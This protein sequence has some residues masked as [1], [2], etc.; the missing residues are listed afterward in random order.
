MDVA[1]TSPTHPLPPLPYAQDALEPVI[2]R[3]TV[4]FHYSRHH[5]GY[6][7]TLNKLIA[8]TSLAHASLEEIVLHAT[9]APRQDTL[10]NNAAQAWNHAFYWRSLRPDGGGIPPAALL[11][12]L[13][14]DFGGFDQFKQALAAAAVGRFGSGWAWLVLEGG[15]LKVVQTSNADTPIVHNQ[16][17]L[18]TIDVWEHAY[19]LDHQNR[20]ADYV[21]EVVDRL[22]NWEFAMA[23]LERRP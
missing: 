18:L 10:F 3:R 16:T 15:K 13:E 20:R 14:T 21:R 6:V 22:L 9:R 4:E 19:Y 12:Q 2:S 1:S 11:L 5:R 17:P 8:G 23:N 7:D